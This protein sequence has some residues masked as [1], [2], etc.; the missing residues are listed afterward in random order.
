MDETGG[1][2]P[3]RRTLLGAGA[4][5]AGAAAFGALD[6]DQALAVGAPS[7]PSGA[8]EEGGSALGSPAAPFPPIIPGTRTVV[9]GLQDT[10]TRGGDLIQ[11]ASNGSVFGVYGTP[12]GD[13]FTQLNVPPGSRILRVDLYAFR[14]VAG[15]LSMFLNRINT[16]VGTFLNL[17]TITTNSSTGVLTGAYTTPF[18]LGS[19]DQLYLYGGSFTNNQNMYVGTVV[20][21]VDQK[22]QLNL[23]STPQR[24]YDS[25]AGFP[26]LGVTKGQLANGATRT[27]DLSMG[28]TGS[29]PQAN[30]RAALVTLTVTNTNSAGFLA[31]FRNG[32]VWPGNSSINWDHA[33]QS[34]AVSTTVATNTLSEINA[35]CSLG[36]NTDFIID[37]QGYYV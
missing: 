16:E 22:P 30:V 20:T 12:N 11:F 9:M 31:L 37:V 33:G 19:A 17:S 28:G 29:V 26:P 34:I 36:S 27:I 24:V 8:A 10:W 35:Y 14:Q 15:T 32:I 2:K 7:G 25:R 23:L 5:G 13:V 4:V 3:T 18:T 21:Y 1:V 6:L